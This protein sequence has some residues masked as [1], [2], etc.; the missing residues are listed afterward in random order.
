MTVSKEQRSYV[1]KLHQVVDGLVA[2]LF[3]RHG[4]ALQCKLG[5]TDCCTDGLTVL[6][7]EASLIAE[8]HAELLEHGS[9]HPVGACAFLDKDGACRI[10]P[11]RP[12]VCRTQGLP[13][14]W[15]ELDASINPPQP[16]EYR[17][18]C[19]IN[20]PQLPAL[21]SLSV[22]DLWSIGPFEH[23]LAILGAPSEH[24]SATDAP[25]PKRLPL[26]ALFR[27]VKYSSHVQ[28]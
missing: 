3:N 13:L 24:D 2:D 17:D 11:N 16:I 6:E 26:R 5:C 27:H 23:R 9:P 1:A 19:P 22:A 8:H 15:L 10:Y 7:A 18:V 28:S 21:A 12:Y 25:P 14:R 4:S 20:A